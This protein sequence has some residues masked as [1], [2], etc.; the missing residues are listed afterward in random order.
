[1]KY[2]GVEGMEEDRMRVWRD[3]FLLQDWRCYG[4]TSLCVMRTKEA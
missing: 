1:M 4:G 2:G 3:M